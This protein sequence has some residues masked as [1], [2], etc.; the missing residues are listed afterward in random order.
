MLT[1]VEQTLFIVL[2]L[3]ALG[4]TYHGFREVYLIVSQG[5][6]QLYLDKLPQRAWTALRV[7]MT[8][9]TTL[10]T[11]P[12]TSLIPLGCCVGFYVLLPCQWVDLLLGF[13]HD[14]EQ[15]LLDFGV[16]YDAYRLSQMF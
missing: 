2:A 14:F 3:F 8:Q 4:A 7:Y 11:R 12:I 6:G 10:K 15:T 1:G 13:F 16:L 9:E 5:Q